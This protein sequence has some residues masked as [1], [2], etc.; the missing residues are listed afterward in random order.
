MVI[1]FQTIIVVGRI[2]NTA[3]TISKIKFNTV[4]NGFPVLIK[5]FSL[6]NPQRN[7]TVRGYITYS[8]IY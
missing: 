1:L 5:G 8:C 3:G 7:G 6:S 4:A 2:L